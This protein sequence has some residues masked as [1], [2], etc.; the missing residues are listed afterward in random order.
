M[1]RALLPEATDA[2]WRDFQGRLRAFVSRRVRQPADVED[3]LQEIFLRI[4]RGLGA[5]QQ[6]D[7]LPAW[8]FQIARNAIMN[9]H[10]SR[11]VAAEMVPEQ[12]DAPAPVA[13]GEDFQGLAELSSC[14]E[15]MIAALP[16]ACRD[17]IRSTELDGQTQGDA[18]RRA[19]M[20]LSGMKS[21]V[22]RARRQLK[23]MLEECCQIELDRRGG[24]VDYSA[25]DPAKSPRGAWQGAKLS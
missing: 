20:S 9:H 2:V 5:I 15:P 25:R 12:I 11:G 8:V 1:S 22:Q 3:I 4:H 24:I 23:N 14:L 13:D 18:A 6:R 17:A 10:R 19:G 16:E 7:R 21:R